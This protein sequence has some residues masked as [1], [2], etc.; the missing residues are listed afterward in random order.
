VDL[1][2]ITIGIAIG[3]QVLVG[4]HRLFAEEELDNSE[5]VS[6]VVRVAGSVQRALKQEG[7]DCAEADRAQRDLIDFG[8]ALFVEEWM[9]QLDD[10]DEVPSEAGALAEFERCLRDATK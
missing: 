10:D 6:R 7:C 8:R 2:S 5:Y 9:K 3:K 1:E 4:E